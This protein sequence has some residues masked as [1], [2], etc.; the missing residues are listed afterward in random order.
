MELSSALLCACSLGLDPRCLTACQ[1]NLCR[2]ERD[3]RTGYE[4]QVVCQRDGIAYVLELVEHLGVREHTAG[5]FAA[6]S[7]DAS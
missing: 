6:E 3:T 7:H 4:N 5:V 1:E 2:Q